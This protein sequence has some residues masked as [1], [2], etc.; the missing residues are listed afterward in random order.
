MGR[1]QVKAISIRGLRGFAEVATL[2]LGLPTGAPGSGL[3]ILVGAN[4]SGKST[5][6]EA[7][8]AIVQNHEVSFTQGRRNFSAGDAVRIG[9]TFA[10][11]ELVEL[12]SVAPGNSETLRTSGAYERLRHILV[13]PSRRHFDPFFNRSEADRTAY[14]AQSGFP[15]VRTVHGGNFNY[16]LFTAQKNRAQFD[17]VMRKVIDP[18]LNWAIDQNDSGQYFL[19]F[20]LKTSFHSSD[21]L[22]DGIISLLFIVDAL[23]DS[24]PGDVIVVDEPELSLHPQL[25]RKLSEVFAE[26]S[27]D[28]QIIIATHSP[29]FANLRAIADGAAIARVHKT[30]EVSRIAQLSA[31]SRGALHGLL[32]NVNNPHVLGL[33]AREVFFL[34]D[35]VVLLEGQEDVVFYSRVEQSIGLKLGGD[36]YG[37][38]V[39]GAGNLPILCA[40]LRDLGFAQ[41][42]GIV[43]GNKAG[44]LEA[45]RR[46]F[47]GYHFDAIPADDVRTKPARQATHTVVGLLD[48]QN[49]AVRPEHVSATRALFEKANQYL[50]SA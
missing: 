33:D 49:Q 21:G 42:V 32:V 24:Q 5:V 48:D 46:D 2:N 13:V 36:V 22:G 26:Y 17:A 50:A 41:V 45:L 6:I 35:G 38:G 15:V 14:M 9:L 20:A 29:Y 31:A 27:A 34:D 40:V 25:Q 10:N 44:D 19:K 18:P 1:E 12:W 7:L 47:P 8:R 4:N 23:Y 28:R 11:D 37:W 39:G 3:T 30:N 16:R 43:D